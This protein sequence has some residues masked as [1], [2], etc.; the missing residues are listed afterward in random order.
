[1]RKQRYFSKVRKEMSCLLAV[2]W[3]R[4]Q[5]HVQ[6][7]GECGVLVTEGWAVEL[8]GPARCKIMPT[9]KPGEM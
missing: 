6:P 9:L 3:G 2:K 4:K 8:Q 1:M 5:L 7:K